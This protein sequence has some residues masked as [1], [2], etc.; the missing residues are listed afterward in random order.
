MVTIIARYN[1]NSRDNIM[2]IDEVVMYASLLFRRRRLRPLHLEGE[3]DDGGVLLDEEVVVAEPLHLAARLASVIALLTQLL[4][5]TVATDCRLFGPSI[6]PRTR[7][8]CPCTLIKSNTLFKAPL[9]PEVPPQ[10]RPYHTKPYNTLHAHTCRPTVQH[11][12]LL[13]ARPKYPDLPLRTP[14][15]PARWR[16]MKQT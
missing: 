3:G 7:M 11:P 15:R 12:S 1:H 16:T 5:I 9:E 13:Y 4:L 8:T 2:M 14:T 10:T 6:V